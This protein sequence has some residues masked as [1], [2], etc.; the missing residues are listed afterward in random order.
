MKLLLEHLHRL[1]LKH[2]VLSCASALFVSVLR[3]TGFALSVASSDFALVIL[4][5]EPGVGI[6]GVCQHPGFLSFY[7]GKENKVFISLKLDVEASIST[8]LP[9]M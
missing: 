6:M 5:P 3:Q 4:V 7:S 1:C 8:L 2:C 9:S